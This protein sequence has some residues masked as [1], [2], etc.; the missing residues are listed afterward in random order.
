M[1]LFDWGSR[2]NRNDSKDRPPE[3]GDGT[4]PAV[5]PGAGPAEGEIAVEGV[6]DQVTYTSEDGVF[7]VV[8]LAV[9]DAP[10]TVTIVGALPGIPK[11]AR[12]RAWGQYETNPRFG[13]QLKVAGFTEMAPQTLE[14]IR[15]YL[16][17]G[18]IKGIG[19]EFAGRIVDRFGLRTFEVFEKEP[20][21]IADVPGIGRQRALAIKSA[22]QEQKGVREVM[23][24]LQGHG[25]SAAFAGRIFK[26]YGKSAISLVRENPYR[27][28]FDVW[29]VGFL[30]ADRL[31]RELGIG[32][33]SPER[34]EAGVRH[35]LSEAASRGHVYVPRQKLEADV[36]QKL[37]VPLDRTHPAIDSLAREGVVTIVSGPSADAQS[38]PGSSQT[39]EL[40][41][42]S[43]LYRAEQAVAQSVARLKRTASLVPLKL[44]V[45]KAARAYESQSHVQLA[46]AQRLALTTGLKEAVSVVT[47][48]PGVGKTTVVR[49]LVHIAERAHLK[50][51]LAAPTGRAAQRMQEATGHAASTV[52]RLLE[53]RPREGAFG[54]NSEAPLDADLIVVDEV[55]MLDVRLAADLL[56]AVAT[57]TRLILVGDSDQL[58]SVGPGRVLADIIAS[59]VVATVQL[60]EIFRQ[61]ASSL[62]VTN[63]HRI[64]AGQLPALGAVPT[65]QQEDNRDFFFLEQDDATQAAELIRDL[66]VSRL[67]K[68][69]GFQPSE[70]QVLA[71][72]HRGELGAG[73]LNLL[74]Q[75]ALTAGAPAVRRGARIYRLADRV[76]QMR[77]N[78]DKEVFNGDVGRVVD[79][80][81]SALTVAFENR[82]II[83]ESDE[84]DE[85]S[86][87][88]A[89]TVHKSQ[90]SEYP[91]VVLPIHAQHFVMLKR[92]LLYTA[93][94]RGKRLVVL[95][96]MR[97]A[98]TMAVRNADAQVRQTQLASILAQSVAIHGD[99]TAAPG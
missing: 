71:P 51:A 96:G 8:R 39:G 31:A 38:E 25:V 50:V 37:S 23:V 27:L 93:L 91:A 3:S 49:G 30:S 98:L 85:L 53:W 28:A 36:A 29:G 66:V 73:N 56:N 54:R 78:Y 4:A 97:K 7:S 47:G 18:L 83:Y 1:D 77:N 86:L 21:R 12:L 48:G 2:P 92:N 75:E 46:D 99:A 32:P 74:L 13:K 81:E 67:P 41:F 55:S 44:D 60:T 69:Y 82:E 63:A 76:M 87:C 24:F 79:V 43:A 57:G 11:G 14:G 72:M 95:V 16:G 9:D 58:P 88:Y 42:E 64:N 19:K 40:V 52:H 5:G 10:T 68:R 84:I 90:G 17:S 62:I 65:G 20:A 61:A 45:Q 80:A 34:I 35:E 70:I 94:T 15:R 26:R 33:Q 59:G 6:V 22:W 89:A